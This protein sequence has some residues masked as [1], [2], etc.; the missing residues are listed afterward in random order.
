MNRVI[1]KKVNGEYSMDRVVTLLIENNSFIREGLKS[2]LLQSQY[3]TV[4]ELKDVLDLKNI[5]HDSGDINLVILGVPEGD[6]DLFVSVQSLKN[7]LPEARIVILSSDLDSSLI[8]QSFSAGADGFIL[9]D[10]SA[11][12]FIGSLNLIMLG[13]KVFPTSMASLLVKGWDS[14]VANFGSQALDDYDLSEREHEIL[15]CLANGDTNKCI[16]RKLDITESTVKVHLKAILRKLGLCNRT[17][18][19]IWAVR[20]GVAPCP[21]INTGNKDEKNLL[22]RLH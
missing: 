1:L 6:S 14:W 15:S 19:A 3:D 20:N 10:I 22:E 9:K 4:I 17:Q 7:L 5:S 21:D 11:S 13:E 2:L 18:A 12:A 8:R 16:A